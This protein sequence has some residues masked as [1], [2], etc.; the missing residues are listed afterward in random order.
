[1]LLSRKQLSNCYTT[2]HLS[3]FL[4]QTHSIMF[5]HAYPV[6]DAA[7]RRAQR[8]NRYPAGLLLSNLS[9]SHLIHMEQYK[10]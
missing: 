7:L 3:S 6:L 5:A 1:M 10:G 9:V 2:D 4:Y 8:H